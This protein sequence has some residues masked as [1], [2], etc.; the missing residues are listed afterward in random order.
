MERQVLRVLA[1]MSVAKVG[2]MIRFFL[3]FP[4]VF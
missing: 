4:V 1:L 3:Y 2:L